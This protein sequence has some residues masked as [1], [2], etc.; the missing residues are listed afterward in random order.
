MA[1][2]I[3]IADDSAPMRAVIRRAC[4]RSGDTILEAADGREAVALFASHQPDWAVIDI[5][6]PGMDG[7]EA[8]RRIR[9]Q[10]PRARVVIV[11]QHEESLWRDEATTSGAA[12]FLLKD[13]LTQLAA[14]LNRSPK[15]ADP[16]KPPTH[17]TTL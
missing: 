7:L 11:T 6:M 5:K 15:P 4:A 1:R 13:D 12:G 9:K 2:T 14:I 3:L 10:F 17:Q 8:T 16:G